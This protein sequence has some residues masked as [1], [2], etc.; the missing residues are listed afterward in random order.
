V[1]DA[2]WIDYWSKRYPLGYDD[3][4][5]KRVGPQVC[6]RGYYDRDD[7]LVVGKWKLRRSYW[8]K[9]KAELESNT[10]D[11]IRDVTSE[12]LTAPLPVRHK[13]LIRLNGVGVPVASA[14]LMVW[15]PDEHT[16]IDR[17]A[18]RSL[19]ENGEIDDP[20]PHAYP[21]YTDYLDVCNAISQRCGRCLRTVD[22]ALYEANGRPAGA[23]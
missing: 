6:A 21:P 4:V 5:L 9:H 19:V 10:D 17:R 11:M 22:R 20:A 12:A 2:D 1:I 14:L 23:A 7:L 3:E 13:I 16:V 8:P 18:V 15:N